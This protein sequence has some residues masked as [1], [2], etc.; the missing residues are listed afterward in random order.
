MSVTPALR[1][2][3]LRRDRQCLAALLDRSH[4]CR[5]QWGQ[6]CSPRLESAL[7]IEHV[8]DEP[9]M[10][11]RAPSDPGHLVAL[12]WDANVVS[13]WGS[14]HRDLLRAYLAGTGARLQW[15]DEL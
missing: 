6:P 7:T 8:K 9:M 11:K 1:E 3:I 12:C 4:Q 5:D 13:L 15:D 2:A 14:A 10:G